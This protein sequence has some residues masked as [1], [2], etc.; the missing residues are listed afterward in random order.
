[1]GNPRKA[2]PDGGPGAV[3]GHQT[4]A[5]TPETRRAIVR[6]LRRLL[7]GGATLQAAGKAL[8]IPTSTAFKI[9]DNHNRPRRRRGMPPAARRKVLRLLAESNLTRTEMARLVG[10]HKGTISRIAEKRIHG[11][12]PTY[13][14]LRA[15]RR[16]EE[17]HLVNLW[18]CPICA[19]KR[20]AN[21]SAV[22]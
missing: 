22:R 12:R 3:A 20:S 10:V 15:P 1:L 7:A 17:G 21:K 18:P 16:C 9:A 8:S 5:R 4:T 14:R 19:A 2:R 11:S 6:R 13:E